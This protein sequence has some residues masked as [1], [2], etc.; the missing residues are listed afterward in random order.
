[1]AE[2]RIYQLDRTARICSG[3]WAEC[4]GDAEAEARARSYLGHWPVVEVWIGT[5]RVAKM[6]AA[7][8]EQRDAGNRG[9]AAVV[10]RSLHPMHFTYTCYDSG[11]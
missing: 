10:S 8:A 9:I 7:G 4:V 1:M 11:R 3:E 2:Y 6:T 5:R